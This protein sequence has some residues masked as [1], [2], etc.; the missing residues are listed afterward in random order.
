MNINR[1]AYPFFLYPSPHKRIPRPTLLR[2]NLEYSIKNTHTIFSTAFPNRAV[3]KFEI[4][5][6]PNLQFNSEPNE[7][8][9]IYTIINQTE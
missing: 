2:N 6:W 9:H 4:P 1:T 3:A 5:L 7:D 8:G